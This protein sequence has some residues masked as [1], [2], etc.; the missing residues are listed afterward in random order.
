MRIVLAV[1]NTKVHLSL[2]R[3]M[4]VPN[5][6]ISYYFFKEF[7]TFLAFSSDWIPDFLMI[8]SGAFSVWTQQGTI[9][10]DKYITFCKNTRELVPQNKELH[11]V[12][13]D[14]LP[15]SFG[16]Y[17][18]K[19]EC[20]QSAEQGWK[21]MEYIENEGIKVMPV[22]HQHEDFKW[23]RKMMEIKDYIGIS[24]ANDVSQA[25]KNNWL[26]KVFSIT[27]D[28]VKTH[29]FAV[30]SVNTLLAYPF[31]SGDSSSWVVGAKYGRIPIFST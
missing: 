2:M 20:E 23:L 26:K 9:D 17:P 28:K 5:L 25:S 22:F 13:L 4:E 27:R 7:L 3:R 24:P 19:E 18:S 15:G 1:N 10:I 16:R 14:V 30:T 6:L 21:N 29:G 8:D 31:Y 11:F 12:N